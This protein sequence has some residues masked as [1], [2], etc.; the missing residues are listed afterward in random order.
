M[1]PIYTAISW[2]LLQWHT[3]W[4]AILP[5]GRFIATNWDWILAIIFLVV[6]VS[7]STRYC[8]LAAVHAGHGM[9]LVEGEPVSAS[10]ISEPSI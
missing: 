9:A 5:D 6:T 3:L 10:A 7:P 8:G 2:I 1:D 4:A